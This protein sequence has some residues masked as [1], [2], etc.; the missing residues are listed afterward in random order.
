MKFSG[1]GPVLEIVSVRVWIVFGACVWLM[2]V[3]ETAISAFAQPYARQSDRLA[4][5]CR[6]RRS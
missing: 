3:G 2:L 6:G 4:P 1:P 5:A